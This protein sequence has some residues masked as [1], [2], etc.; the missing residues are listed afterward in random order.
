M[1]IS[2]CKKGIYFYIDWY[3]NVSINYLVIY[4]STFNQITLIFYYKT[5][6]DIQVLMFCNEL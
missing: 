2:F 1:F 3:K 5:V 6:I 4:K